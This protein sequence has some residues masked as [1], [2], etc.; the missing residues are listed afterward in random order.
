MTI[1]RSLQTSKS[2]KHV[3]SFN[4]QCKPT[5]N[6]KQSTESKME[7]RQKKTGLNTHP[8]RSYQAGMPSLG[9]IAS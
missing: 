1:S 2:A 9:A 3:D 6:N 8:G 4:E 7:Y 5:V